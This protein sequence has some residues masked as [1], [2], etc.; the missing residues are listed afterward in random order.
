MGLDENAITGMLGYLMT[1]GGGLE[2]LQY[3]C[4]HATDH[5][6][7]SNDEDWLFRSAVLQAKDI[8]PDD[9]RISCWH[10][11]CLAHD[12]LRGCPASNEVIQK[13][14]LLVDDVN[15]RAEYCRLRL[16]GHKYL[17]NIDSLDR[18]TA[19]NLEWVNKNAANDHVPQ[20]GI[21]FSLHGEI[22]RKD[23][24][25]VLARINATKCLIWL[26]GECKHFFTKFPVTEMLCFTCANMREEM[27]TQVIEYLA[28]RFPV[29][30]ADCKDELGNNPLWYLL[31]NKYI[32]WW[33]KDCGMAKALVK[34]GCSPDAL[35]LLGLSFQKMVDNV[36]DDQ[37]EKLE[38]ELKERISR[39]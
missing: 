26:M 28:G 23:I 32:A 1:M 8:L 39:Q 24:A 13:C 33:R 36:T 20:F 18:P 21:A 30:V 10:S 34:A 16:P 6:F 27:G 4:K 5:E 3:V 17:R 14:Q 25:W 7:C 29:K 31:H 22:F 12:N 9:F 19:Q 2:L 37:R 15:V 35:N 38:T 11:W